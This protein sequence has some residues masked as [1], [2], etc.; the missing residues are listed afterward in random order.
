MWVWSNNDVIVCLTSFINLVYA[1]SLCI[2]DAFMSAIPRTACLPFIGIL[3]ALRVL[4]GPVALAL[5]SRDNRGVSWSRTVSAV[6]AWKCSQTW[7]TAVFIAASEE[8]CLYFH[9]LVTRVKTK[10]ATRQLFS[11]CTLNILLC[12]MTSSATVDIISCYFLA[13]DS[14]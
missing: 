7:L 13:R 3:C 11:A 1:Y 6:F 9:I 10:L 2:T 4:F 8:P 12:C 5:H 14:I